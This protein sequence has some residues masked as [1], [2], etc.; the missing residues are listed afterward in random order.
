MRQHYG[1]FVKK[2]QI[3]NIRQA[4][5]RVIAA[6]VISLVILGGLAAFS[7]NAIPRVWASSAI[8][9]NS[10]DTF[11]GINFN[12]TGTISYNSTAVTGGSLRLK[13]TDGTI[14]VTTHYALNVQTASSN[15]VRFILFAHVNDSSNSELGAYIYVNVSTGTVSY[16]F[17]ARNADINQDGTVDI[18]DYS[19]FSY[20]YGTCPGD[21][22]YDPRADLANTGCIGIIDLSIWNIIVGDPAYR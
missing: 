21:A 9:V 3:V 7:P 5:S 19:F 12:T 10:Q 2:T 16:Y 15:Y 1:R 13:V 6:V 17:G 22:K 18:I 20:R 8:K 11:E 14:V 4:K